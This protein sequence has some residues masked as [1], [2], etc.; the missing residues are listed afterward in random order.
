[1]AETGDN[2]GGNRSPK[3]GWIVSQ[4]AKRDN[5]FN[6]TEMR[7][8]SFA[9]LATANKLVSE[10]LAK[11]QDAVQ[12][13]SD[14]QV[15]AQYIEHD[16]GTETGYE[17]YRATVQDDM[18]VRPTTG[19]AVVVARDEKSDEFTVLTAYPRNFDRDAIRPVKLASDVTPNLEM[20]VYT[21][22][23]GIERTIRFADADEYLALKTVLRD[24]G[25]EFT[26]ILSDAPTDVEFS[27]VET[28][29]QLAAADEL[30]HA[31]KQNYKFA[32]EG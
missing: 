30:L 18:K 7:L 6:W 23:D 13:V 2:D 4:G 32:M 25:A 9:S 20:R 16:F 14:G 5:E 29:Q 22:F 12:R 1:M 10:I 15:D 27:Y 17:G 11:C 8:G 26:S 31:L 3:T 19:V 24:R 28:E 21:A